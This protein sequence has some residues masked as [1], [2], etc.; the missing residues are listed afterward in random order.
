MARAEADIA[1]SSLCGAV[2]EYTLDDPLWM[3]PIEL[4]SGLDESAT[5]EEETR[6][7]ERLSSEMAGGQVIRYT[8]G[9]RIST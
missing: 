6:Q 1:A 8:N 4:A 2:V 7:I 5:W 9:H 3:A